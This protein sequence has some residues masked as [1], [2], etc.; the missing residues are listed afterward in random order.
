MSVNM[1]QKLSRGVKT[2]TCEENISEFTLKSFVANTLVKNST[3]KARVTV[4]G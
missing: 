1:R 3:V 4:S 2:I